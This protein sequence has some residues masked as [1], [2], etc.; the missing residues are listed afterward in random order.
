MRRRA[1]KGGRED[2]AATAV[3]RAVRCWGLQ[4]P[5]LTSSSLRDPVL[6]CPEALHCAQLGAAQ[7][8]MHRGGS[9]QE[10]RKHC[11]P[12]AALTGLLPFKP[13]RPGSGPHSK[14][15]PAFCIWQKAGPLPLLASHRKC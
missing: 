13:P 9:R 6:S 14:P 8:R 12:S 11:V 4:R 10:A 7:Y 1:V 5:A 15:A 2:A 3:Q